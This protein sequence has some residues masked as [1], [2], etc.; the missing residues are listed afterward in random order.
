MNA[1]KKYMYYDTASEEW[2]TTTLAEL[3][4]KNDTTLTICELL[5]DGTPGEQMSYR[6][7]LRS[8]PRPSAITPAQNDALE[9]IAKHLAAIRF[10]IAVLITLVA[11]ARNNTHYGEASNELTTFLS[12]L[13]VGAIVYFILAIPTIRFGK[14]K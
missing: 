10:G 8:L 9:T 5:P 14:K 7:L 2:T 1:D 13:I 12:A 11:F 4:R 3:L 6:D